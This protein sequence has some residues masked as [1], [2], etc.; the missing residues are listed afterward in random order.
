MSFSYEIRFNQ[1]KKSD[2]KFDFLNTI[3]WIC[4]VFYRICVLTYKN[5][6]KSNIIV[7]KMSEFEIKWFTLYTR[8]VFH[9]VEFA[10]DNYQTY[11]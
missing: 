1:L 11:V 2:Y 3:E 10:F 7:L 9:E 8:C 5:R 4:I 6:I